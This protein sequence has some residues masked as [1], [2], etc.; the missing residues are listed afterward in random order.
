[1]FNPKRLIEAAWAAVGVFLAKAFPLI[2]SILLIRVFGPERYGQYSMTVATI[3]LVL[4]ATGAGLVGGL[5]SSIA[6]EQG[7]KSAE[8][9]LQS[10]HAFAAVNLVLLV[11]V[12]SSSAAAA[13]FGLLDDQLTALITA[14]WAPMLLL[15]AVQVQL[16]SQSAVATVSG[17]LKRLAFTSFT[18]GILATLLQLAGGYHWGVNG[19]LWGMALGYVI[20][21][22]LQARYMRTY[23][24]DRI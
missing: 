21:V 2:G 5:V 24:V 6:G 16:A 3:N 7:I 17:L 23:L 11:L 1:M 18:G 4:T 10:V 9:R 15:V 13:H 12:L 20:Q 14:N 8:A 19:A 22:L